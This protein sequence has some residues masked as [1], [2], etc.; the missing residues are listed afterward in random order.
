MKS[1]L[2]PLLAA[3][4]LLHLAAA[5]VQARRLAVVRVQAPGVAV[6]VPTNRVFVAA[7]VAPSAV[8]V[9][10]QRVFVGTPGAAVVAPSYGT[11]CT[12]AGA[13]VLPSAVLPPVR[14]LV[15]PR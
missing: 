10:R 8:I 11:G 6:A 4:V 5:P 7:A 9:Q 2:S 3:L 14:V 13:V 12:G 15:V 1:L